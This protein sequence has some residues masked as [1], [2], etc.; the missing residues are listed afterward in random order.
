VQL[1]QRLIDFVKQNGKAVAGVIAIAVFVALAAAMFFGRGPADDLNVVAQWN[2]TIAKLGIEPVFPPEEDVY[3]G[4]LFAVITEDRRSEGSIAKE[5]LLNRAIKI[6]H[7]DLTDELNRTYNAVPIFPKTAPRPGSIHDPW[8]QEVNQSG[9]FTTSQAPR[10]VLGIAAFPGF[11]IH[12]QRSASGGLSGLFGLLG[13]SYQDDDLVEVRIPVAETYGVPSGIAAG[14]LSA[15]CA[16]PFTR[17]YCTDITLRRHLSHVARGLFDKKLDASGALYYLVD[18]QLALVNRVYLTRSIEQK[19]RLSA[20]SV[21]KQ[22]ND[23]VS[24]LKTV[25]SQP[26][27]VPSAMPPGGSQ[28]GSSQPPASSSSSASPSQSPTTSRPA[29]IL[30]RLDAKIPG[31]LM[32]ILTSSDSSYELK[33]TFQRPVAIGY[34]AVRARFPSNPT[35]DN[36]DGWGTTG[37]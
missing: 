1:F 5:P 8:M 31:G 17:D 18:V 33:Q 27:A 4:D 20:T 34:R 26:D 25:T 6:D 36:N 16:D 7:I 11:T 28:S 22:I 12:Q 10:S 3:V 15:Y 19:R 37:K 13:G 2:N 21:L 29:D 24:N 14:R 9:I 35:L 30:E 32:T 23:A